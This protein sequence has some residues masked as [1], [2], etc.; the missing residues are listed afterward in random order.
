MD[1][2]K[3][4]KAEIIAALLIRSAD[5][6]VHLASGVTRFASMRLSTEKACRM[7]PAYYGGYP[8]DAAAQ[9]HFGPLDKAR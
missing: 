9:A 4:S 1:C 6:D 2:R 5:R 3:R 8:V 7:A